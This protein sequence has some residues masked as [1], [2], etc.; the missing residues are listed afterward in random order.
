[1]LVRSAAPPEPASAFTADTLKID[2]TFRA[3]IS[4]YFAVAY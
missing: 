3:G 2:R 1:M 4:V